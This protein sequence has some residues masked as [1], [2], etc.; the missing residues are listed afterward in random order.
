MKRVLIIGANSYIGTSVEQYLHS[1]K[2]YSIDTL[3][4]LGDSWKDYDFS[5]YDVALH[6]A[7]IAHVKPKTISKEIYDAVNHVL[8]I[9]VAKR[10]K[11]AGVKQFVFM[12]SMSVYGMNKGLNLDLITQS[13]PTLNPSSGYGESKLAAEKDL[14]ALCDENFNIC[15]VRSPMVY[16]LGSKGNFMRL[17]RL[18]QITPI[19]PNLHNRRSMI[20][21]DNLCEFIKCAIDRKLCGI[22]FPQNR[23]YGDTMQIVQT[24]A[25]A[26]NHK[27][28]QTSLLNPFVRVSA[29]HVSSLRKLFGSFCYDQEMSTYEFDYQL[30]SF[31]ESLQRIIKRLK[32]IAHRY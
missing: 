9:D 21:I 31:E 16:G 13:T 23:E 22:F 5:Q 15:I 1:S 18:A 14:K 10:A 20:Y 26:F 28:W 4:T 27:V 25:S 7:G 11:L 3:D 19:F 8:A 12:S 32:Q 6:V 30:V 17:V 29:K 24:A 2:Q